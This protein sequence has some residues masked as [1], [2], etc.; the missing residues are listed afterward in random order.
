YASS[1]IWLS[2]E[3]VATCGDDRKLFF[4]NTLA[5]H[6]PIK[7]IQLPTDSLP[8]SMHYNQPI[9]CKTIDLIASVSQMKIEGN[10]SN[11][12][13]IGTAA[14]TFHLIPINWNGNKF[15]KTFEAHSKA[16]IMIR[17]SKDNSTL[18]TCGEDGY[19][20]IW[21]K[22]GM[23]RSNI[24]VSNVSP[25]YAISWSPDSNFLCYTNDCHLIVKPLTPHS[26]ALEWIAHEGIIIGV[27][28]S[29]V[30]NKIISIAEDRRV[31]IWDSSSRLIYISGIHPSPLT[32]AD[33]SS[34]GELF[35]VCTFDSLQLHDQLGY[36]LSVE[37]LSLDGVSLVC[38]S[39]DSNQVCCVCTSGRVIFAHVLDRVLE[40]EFWQASNISRRAI[41]MINLSNNL[42][43][44]LECN[45]SILQF[46]LKFK[47]LIVVTKNQC[48]IYDVENLVMPHHFPFKS[49]DQVLMIEQ[50][51]KHFGLFNLNGLNIYSYEGKLIKTIKIPNLK[52]I[53]SLQSNYFS[54]N[55]TLLVYRDVIHHHNVHFIELDSVRFNQDSK[56]TN[57]CYQHHIEV[58]EIKLEFD[59][60]RNKQGQLCAIIDRNF[61]LYIIS[62]TSEGKFHSAKLSSAIKHIYWHNKFNLLACLNENKTLSICLYPNVAFLDSSLLQDVIIV[63][64][65]QNISANCR[66][67]EFHQNRITLERQD[68]VKL[69]FSINPFIISLHKHYNNDRLD[70]AIRMCNFLEQSLNEIEP[71][72]KNVRNSLW[73]TLA[74]MAL[75][76]KQFKAAEIAYATINR[77]DKVF[78]LNKIKELP[79]KD[80]I[81]IE[82]DLLC[83]KFELAE[84]SF[85]QKGYVLR[86]IHL[87]L[88]LH[89][90]Q[91][92]LELAQKYNNR[93][94]PITVANNIDSNEMRADSNEEDF[95]S[96]I[97]VDLIHLVVSCRNHSNKLR[98]LDENIEEFR[99]FN[100]SLDFIADWNLIDQILS[101]DYFVYKSI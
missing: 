72:D 61:D 96:E 66:I 75:E 97:K 62:W 17:W 90:W 25:V 87:N 63:I 59:P 35:A 94:E 74:V 37:K 79:S 101:K 21:S 29:S 44:I 18:A 9:N 38:W 20:K 13:A 47:H 10:S 98:K 76:S 64:S 27:V 80:L 23:L 41:K 30:N 39:S 45:D 1:A 34:D 85:I 54:L 28:W 71:I 4:W 46:H 67:T 15:D 82:M 49:Q 48:S 77:I 65:N 7:M 31:K 36:C 56:Q 24:A 68:K 57:V 19:V 91:R 5:H 12:I 26:K 53:Q 92:A 22:I 40:S 3:I 70:E 89:N 14:G 33:W 93:F 86:A 42:D 83:G 6:K 78:Y 73:T 81:V 55:D 95:P 100:N 99:N 51:S 11:Q 8:T 50:S 43:E 69:Y 84:Q 32:S 58:I 88:Q 16:I 52:Q 60:Q 2:N